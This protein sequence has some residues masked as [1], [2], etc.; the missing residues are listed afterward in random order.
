MLRALQAVTGVVLDEHIKTRFYKTCC[1]VF[2]GARVI[3]CKPGGALVWPAHK[4]ED[5]LLRAEWHGGQAWFCRACGH[6]NAVRH[7]V[8]C[9][10]DF[11]DMSLD[12]FDSVRARGHCSC[13]FD[14]VAAAL[15]VSRLL[16]RV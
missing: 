2:K 14:C 11:L 4:M 1:G 16:V 5:A 9:V 6:A 12:D 7:A 10:D 8:N 3:D 13:G 15:S